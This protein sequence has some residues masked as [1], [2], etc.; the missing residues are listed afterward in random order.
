VV[1]V[2]ETAG[3]LRQQEVLRE[4]IESISS[5]LELRPL[6]TRIVH[7]ACELLA[8]DYGTIGLVDESR[9]V[10]RTE[11]TYRMPPDEMG[12]EMAPGVGLAGMVLE[13]QRPVVHDRYGDVQ[14]PTQ[15]DLA[16]HSV[17][18]MPIFWH[19]RM[20]GFFGI[21][22]EPPRRFSGRDVD[23]LALFAR[24]AAVAIENARRYEREQRR[25]ERLALIA[26]VGRIVTAD[27]MLEDLLHRA[28]S[29]IH[30]LLGY[31]NVDV[32]LLSPDDPGTLVIIAVAGRF[33]ELI[34]HEV[35]VPV[36]RGIMGQ[37][38][39]QR[40]AILI[41]DVQSHPQYIPMPGATGITAELAVPMVLG[42]RVLGVLNVEAGAPFDEEDTAGL[43]IVADQL[44]GAIENARLFSRVNTALQ[45]T[46]LL[47][48]SSR[49]INAAHDVDEVIVSYL[50]LVA[51]RGRYTCSVAVYDFDAAGQ[52]QAVL[53]RGR[54]SPRG[55]LRRAAERHPYARDELDPIL[56]AG[57]TATISDVHSDPRVA[58][59][60]RRIQRRAGRPA[61]A[62]IPL[63]ARG[64][65]IGLVILSHHQVHEWPEAALHPYQVTAQQLATAIDHRRQQRLLLERGQQVAVLEERQRLARELHDSVTQLIFSTALIAQS[66][67][68][69]WRRDPQEGE[70]RIERLLDLSRSA[71]AEMRAL[72]FELRPP[73]DGSAPDGP[74]LPETSKDGATPGLVRVQ[75]DGL[76]EALRQHVVGI[77]SDGLV[78]EVEDAGY[79][80]QPL[81]QEEALYRIAQEALNNV[82]KHARARRAIL[83]LT[84]DGR[85]IHLTVT[86]DGVGFR[87]GGGGRRA[88]GST[89]AG[90]GGNGT[91]SPPGPGL[92][93][94]AG[95][96]LPGGGFGLRTMRE[97]AQAL[98]GTAEV[99]AAPGRGTIVDVFLP[100][101]SSVAEVR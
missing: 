31:A 68:P 91:A 78:V 67:G 98:G 100:P 75:R 73:E 85:G 26:R 15:P 87:Q 62:M 76:A 52:R 95:H 66:V 39:L 23:T 11:A 84:L 7:H 42:E 60:L 29:A 64:Q 54:W 57:Q 90:G 6:L 14:L 3:L 44:A 10:V 82:I 16:E 69:A 19:N 59:E 22:G 77:S 47:Y 27:L 96:G 86:D 8:A 72:L 30:E 36:T 40:R 56:D 2:A 5:E 37:A 43:Q 99:R 18:G 70:R 46:R 25:I 41:N 24:H 101:A 34:S 38:V 58:E 81:A 71:L 51:A 4:F 88:A 83:R 20:I 53:V 97:R 49:R 63:I 33:R 21:G 61:L 35:R 48:E 65:R 28:G 50:E 79:R 92:P 17:V 93:A 32:G 55:G 80:R 9:N 94:P 45:E 89:T 13:T 74:A 12:A 1:D